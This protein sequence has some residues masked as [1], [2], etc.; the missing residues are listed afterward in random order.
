MGLG[1][2]TNVL[3]P[4]L[5]VLTKSRSECS[6]SD[7]RT[8]GFVVS[9]GLTLSLCLHSQ[10]RISS[11]SLQVLP[12]NHLSSP[13]IIL[14]LRPLKDV[15][16]R[17]W[18]EKGSSGLEGGVGIDIRGLNLFW[19]KGELSPKW[20]FDNCLFRQKTKRR[21]PNLGLGFALTKV[22][23]PCHSKET[24]EKRFQETA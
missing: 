14:A 11:A 2:L 12:R 16:L 7:T 6:L 15:V 3:N 20:V 17:G 1:P 23:C 10:H 4:P 22:Q 9:L 5:R 8:N 13:G 24:W 21:S 18:C 19:P